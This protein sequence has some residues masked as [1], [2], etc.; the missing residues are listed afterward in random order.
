[1]NELPEFVFVELKFGI[2][3]FVQKTRPNL[4]RRV[5]TQISICSLLF[6]VATRFVSVECSSRSLNT[7]PT[8]SNS[9]ATNLYL[10]E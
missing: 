4:S 2:F 7:L 3:T 1:M 9:Q 5:N 6:M 10:R 8:D